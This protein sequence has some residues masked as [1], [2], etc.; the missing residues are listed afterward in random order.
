MVID[1]QAVYLGEAGVV[2]VEGQGVLDGVEQDVQ[3][4]KQCCAC[5]QHL[6]N[7]H[8]DAIPAHPHHESH[9]A[10]TL[11]MDLYLGCPADVLASLHL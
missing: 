10:Y 6:H 9:T 7:Q 4:I 5:A 8:Q 1:I 2:G 11:G 3:A